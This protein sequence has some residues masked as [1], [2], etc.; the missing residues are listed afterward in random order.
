VT[1]ARSLTANFAV[2][3]F[4]VNF[5]SG[6]NGSITG[7]ASQNVVLGLNA[8]TVTAV[9]ALGYH[10]VNWTEGGSVVSS[11]PQLSITNVVAA[12]SFTA[13]FAIDT[14]AV[15][16]SSDARGSVSQA[17][18]T[19]VPFGSSITYSFTPNAGYQVVDVVVD[20]ASVGAPGSYT[21]SNVIGNG[22]SVKVVFIPDGD[23]NSDGKVNIA[24]ALSALQIAVGLNQATPAQLRHGD[25]APLDAGGIPTP[26]T[27]I[28][29]ADALVILR[30]S[31]GLTSGF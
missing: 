12:R 5:L 14:F 16:A 28:Q 31:V 18:T 6:G 8:S 19:Q 26:D 13:N 20:G 10:F 11:S 21:F 15:V 4:A 27:Q 22:H 23:L 29:V 7:A 25:L 3:S 24:D 2:D 17:G 30:K 9:P 1:S